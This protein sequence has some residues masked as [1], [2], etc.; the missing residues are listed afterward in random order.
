LRRAETVL[1]DANALGDLMRDH[2]RLKTRVA[3]QPGPILTGVVAWEENPLRVHHTPNRE[4]L[5]SGKFLALAP[6]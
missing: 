3:A 5:S 4:L 2:A 1:L 6:A